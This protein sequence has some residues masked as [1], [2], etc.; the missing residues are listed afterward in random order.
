MQPKKKKIEFNLIL[1]I[2]KKIPKTNTSH[3]Y[4]KIIKSSQIVQIS[5]NLT[6]KQVSCLPKSYNSVITNSSEDIE[7]FIF[8]IT[9]VWTVS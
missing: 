6:H 5:L 8:Y 3:I 4:Q 2:P 1:K 7:V 9:N